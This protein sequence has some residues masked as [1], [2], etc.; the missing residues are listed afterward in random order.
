MKKRMRKAVAIA[1]KGSPVSGVPCQGQAP[2]G[3]G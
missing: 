2:C 3:V 1:A